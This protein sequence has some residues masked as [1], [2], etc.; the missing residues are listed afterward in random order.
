MDLYESIVYRSLI[1]PQLI[2]GMPRNL[3]FIL[4][5]LTLAV[6]LGL[7][8]I[9]FVPFAI[10]LAVVFYFISKKDP[11]FFDIYMAMVKMPEV[12]E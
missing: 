2:F 6:S 4:I 9:W 11:Y 12:L 1:F 8:Q 7:G 5:T 3:F 10:V